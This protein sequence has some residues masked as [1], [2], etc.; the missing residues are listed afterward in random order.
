[1]LSIIEAPVNIFFMDLLLAGTL[2]KMMIVIIFGGV[3]L[4]LRFQ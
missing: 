3:N 2:D 1:M 4:F